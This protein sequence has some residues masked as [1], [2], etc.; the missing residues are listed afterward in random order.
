MAKS[1]NQKKKLLIILK[2]LTESSDEAHP[3]SM[4][5]ILEG[6]ERENI[7]AERKSIYHDMDTLRECGFDVEHIGGKNGGYYLSS[8]TF[9]LAELKVLADA[10]CAS[11]FITEKKSRQLIQKIASLASKHEAK[12][13]RREVYVVNRVKSENENILYNID[14]IYRAIDSN[15]QIMFQYLTYTVRKEEDF[16]RGGALYEVS[17]IALT[18]NDENYYLIAYDSFA[19]MIKHYRVDRMKNI[20]LSEKQCDNTAGKNGFDLAL[21]CNKTFGMFAGEEEVVNV[22][23]PNSL[24]GVVLDRF[25]KDVTLHEEGPER[26]TARLRVQV[27]AQFFGWITGLGSE[28]KIISPAYV[29]QEYATHLE[30]TLKQYK[31]ANE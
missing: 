19:Q 6:L 8:R 16:R 1:E 7:T 9:E 25:G 31:T 4:K 11:R 28:V 5:E 18:W 3:L 15:H 2:M 23:F 17:P 14:E 27:S 21:Y 26:F 13:L 24:I 12:Q 29:A 30:E 22:S 10:V 20:F